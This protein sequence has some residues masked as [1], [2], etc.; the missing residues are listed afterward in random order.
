MTSSIGLRPSLRWDA[1]SSAPTDR[2]RGKQHPY[3]SRA[4]Q[5]SPLRIEGAASSAPTERGRGKQRP[6]RTRAGQAPPLQEKK[7]R[8]RSFGTGVTRARTKRRLE[9]GVTNKTPALRQ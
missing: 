9:A 3:G 2:G 7:R 4:Q 6:Y 5:A 8:S 1:A